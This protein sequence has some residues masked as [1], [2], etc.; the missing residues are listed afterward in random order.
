MFRLPVCRCGK[1]RQVI[2]VRGIGAVLQTCAQVASCA[3]SCCHVLLGRGPCTANLGVDRHACLVV[4]HLLQV[5]WWVTLWNWEPRLGC[6]LQFGTCYGTLFC[7]LCTALWSWV[8]H[9][10]KNLKL[11]VGLV[12]AYAVAWATAHG[13][14]CTHMHPQC[15]LRCILWPLVACAGALDT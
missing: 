3:E 11:A 1:A 9:H 5:C 14:C 12:W 15:R 13:A 2:T 10:N 4:V 7:W 6:R 8:D